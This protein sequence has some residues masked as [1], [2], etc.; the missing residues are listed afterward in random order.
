MLAEASR[1]S[2]AFEGRSVRSLQRMSGKLLTWSGAP[3]RNVLQRLQA[4]L[5][6]ICPKVDV[7]DGQRAACQALLKAPAKKT[8]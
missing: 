2:G 5:D 8:S 7:A 6:G 4:Q 3:Q 1:D